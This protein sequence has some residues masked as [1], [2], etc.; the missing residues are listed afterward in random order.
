[1]NLA[2]ATLAAPFVRRVCASSPS[3]TLLHA[4]V[5]ASGMAWSD[6]QALTASPHV[7]LVAVAE[8]DRSKLTDV[9]KRFPEVRVYT[10]GRELFDKEKKLDSV[11][12]STP[13]HM[14]AFFA[15]RALERGLHVYC[16]KP[17]THCLQEAR[18]LTEAA[19]AARKLVTQMGIQIHAHTCHR[20]VVRLIHDGA[21]GK[22]K[23]VHSWSG[24]G[25]GDTGPRPDRRDPV[26][27]GFDWNLWLGGAA[28][29]P[30]I[31][32]Y[33]HPGVWR[34]RLD[35][36]TGTFGDMA[37]HIL[38]PVFTSLALTAPTTVRS[39][40]PA[41]GPDSWSVDVQVCLEFP[42]T[43]HTAGPLQLNWYNGRRRPPSA[44]QGV[45]GTAKLSDQGTIYFGEKGTLYS[46]YI[47]KP[48]LLPA[49][50]FAGYRIPDVASTDHYQQF[51]D[52]CRGI[53]ATE[54]PFS[55]AGPLTESVLLGCLATHFPQKTLNWNATEL[56]V[57]NVDEANAFVGQNYRKGWEV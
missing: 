26:P 23:E 52:A 38:D 20:T 37:C 7:K 29:R 22:V 34:K 19:A 42:A 8:V 13:D 9:L 33:Y 4:S 25:W 46:P 24:K 54:T 6:I 30:F 51:M 28:E 15:M 40:G 50:R 10:D 14:H 5:G 49:D 2:A 17:L 44:V 45:I 57:S 35:F 48:V 1:M 11:N 53:G 56:K 43:T 27:D 39:E 12:V 55:Y 18:K 41:P 32:D 21:I 47:D 31:K 16:Q 36:G 3:E